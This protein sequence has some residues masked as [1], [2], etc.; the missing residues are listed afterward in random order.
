MFTGRMDWNTEWVD[1]SLSS[2]T[3]LVASVGHHAPQ[4]CRALLEAA[5]QVSQHVVEHNASHHQLT[6]P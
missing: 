4:L 2:Y 5:K 3:P 6:A 1:L